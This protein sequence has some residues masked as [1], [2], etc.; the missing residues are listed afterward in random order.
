MAF[1]L[2]LRQAYIVAYL[3]DVGKWIDGSNMRLLAELDILLMEQ[4]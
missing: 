2:K 3:D 1:Y 4:K